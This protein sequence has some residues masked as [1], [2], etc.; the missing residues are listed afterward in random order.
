MPINPTTIPPTIFETFP[1]LIKSTSHKSISSNF[2]RSTLTPLHQQSRAMAQSTPPRTS[3]PPDFTKYGVETTNV[4]AGPGVDLQPQQ[5][6]ILGC[7]L[8]LF[9]GR[10][11]KRKLT[12]WS[13]TASFHDPLTNATGRKQ[14]EAQWYG[15]KVAF[16]EIERLHAKV[17]SAGNPMEMDLKTRY[18]V[19]GIGSEQTI[20]SK[21]VVTTEGEGE[22]MRVKK[23]EDRW[24]GEIQAGPVK[25]ALRE[26]N[27]VTV[28][29]MV[30]VPKSIEE[31]EGKK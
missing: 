26:L 18:K 5:K 14:Y 11:S 6:V 2:L 16:S 19:K 1:R 4:P 30:S 25:N 22:S 7:V 20:E 15:L 10:P 29:M 23:L 28:P 12:L 27:S 21:I 31:E 17:T 3:S 24:G 9:T 8:D 13:D